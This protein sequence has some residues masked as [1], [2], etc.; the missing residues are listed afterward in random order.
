VAT[1][2]ST[3][4]SRARA[5]HHP[6]FDAPGRSLPGW[7]SE[8]LIPGLAA[9][10][11]AH[12]PGAAAHGVDRALLAD[13][14]AWARQPQMRDALDGRKDPAVAL[15]DLAAGYA[16]KR[17]YAD[18][19]PFEALPAPL[20]RLVRQTLDTVHRRADA[21][22]RVFGE[23]PFDEDPNNLAKLCEELAGFVP[24]R[25]LAVHIDTKI[26]HYES[27]V[28]RAMRQIEYL[29]Q[30]AEVR[31]AF[32]AFVLAL[33]LPRDLRERLEEVGGANGVALFK[34]RLA[35]M[36]RKGGRKDL[37]P[38]A[39][40]RLFALPETI[41]FV[42]RYAGAL[43]TARSLYA[44]EEAADVPWTG[45]RQPRRNR[46]TGYI[47]AALM[48]LD[49]SQRSLGQVEPDEDDDEAAPAL[50]SLARLADPRAEAA[51]AAALRSRT[52]EQWVVETA[53]EAAPDDPRWRTAEALFV[54]HLTGAEIVAAGLA[55]ERGI[56]DARAAVN[57]L[58]ANQEVWDAWAS[59]LA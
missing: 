12:G 32:V 2:T 49:R 10:L 58:R 7:T 56:A 42:M 48:Q 26:R 40:I 47:E 24:R 35:L 29:A 50:P 1:R 52:F 19:V 55:N 30:R 6:P 25:P 44:D 39:T 45:K 8:A 33:E 46:R 51:F 28:S 5:H 17:L 43:E 37:D 54:R 27:A 3:L 22:A 36:A 13:L 57:A 34:A 4:P 14:T 41:A 38:V 31:D 11:T 20:R 16:F 59:E 23:H 21:W 9:L 15:R 53:L 18:R